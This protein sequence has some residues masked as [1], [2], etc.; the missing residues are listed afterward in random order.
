[1]NKLILKVKDIL[2]IHSK[3]KKIKLLAE[4]FSDSIISSRDRDMKII[5]NWDYE[6]LDK[7]MCPIYILLFNGWL[8]S[9][10]M[11]TVK[12]PNWKE[13]LDKVHFNIW[14][15]TSNIK[16]EDFFQ[17]AQKLYP[18]FNS[19]LNFELSEKTILPKVGEI[20]CGLCFGEKHIGIDAVLFFEQ[21]SRA[22]I[23]LQIDTI[24]D[25]K[26]MGIFETD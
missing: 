22:T 3:E 24:K 21:S 25:L 17:L 8:F 10:A 15:A 9:H 20:I 11:Q 18:E 12:P 4:S 14:K 7:I 23:K 19:A 26:D 16:M 5:K 6:I 1:M 2:S 13:I